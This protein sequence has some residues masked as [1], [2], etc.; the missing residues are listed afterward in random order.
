MAKQANKN[1]S[2]KTAVSKKS[3]AKKTGG[4]VKK[5]PAKKTA[6]KKTGGA[7]KKT[8]VKKTAAKK[9][10]AKKTGGAVKKTPVKK[11]ATTQS[12]GSPSPDKKRT[13]KIV[14]SEGEFSSRITGNTPKQAANKA[15]TRLIKQRRVNKKPTT[16]K[17][18]FTIKETTRGSKQKTYSYVGQQQKLP[19]PTTYEIRTASGETKQIVNR[20]RNRVEKL[21][22]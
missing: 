3:V 16:G 12:A 2:K 20:Y 7:V 4:A 5:T 18:E 1:V 13:F 9:T 15:L 14:L 19:T 22:V 10:A 17:I 11:T 21:K 8:P 6:A